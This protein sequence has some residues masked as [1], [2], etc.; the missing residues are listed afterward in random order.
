M[1]AEVPH[2]EAGPGAE[3]GVLEGGLDPGA[4]V[5]AGTQAEREEGSE[6]ARESAVGSF[7]HDPVHFLWSLAEDYHEK[8]VPWGQRG[9]RLD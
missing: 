2:D 7:L 3:P 9:T 1:P 6:P 4:D 5:G 8:I